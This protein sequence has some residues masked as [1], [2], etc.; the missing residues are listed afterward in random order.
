M[1]T[2][3]T[4]I[5]KTKYF[6]T[7]I[8]AIMF[9]L[10]ITVSN[11]IKAQTSLNF[12]GT[13]DYV[14]TNYSGILGDNDRTVE[15]WFKTS[16]AGPKGFIEWGTQANAQRFTIGVN[17]SKIRVE[18]FG[19]GI[20]STTNI[21]DDKWHHVAVVYNSSL[22]TNKLSIYIDGALDQS[23]N[24]HT[25]LNTTNTANVMIGQSNLFANRPI[26][27]EM[28]E[29]RIWDTAKSQEEIQDGMFHELDGSEANLTAYYS[30]ESTTTAANG[31]IDL[32][33]G[34]NGTMNNMDA[35]DI[36]SS[37]A[38]IRTT[39]NQ[40]NIRG[41]W[42]ST[43]MA[44]SL[45]SDGLWMNVNS[46]LTQT[47]YATFGHNNAGT[48][49]VTNDLPIGIEQR[50]EQ[51]WNVEET[52][53]VTS[54][55]TFDLSTIHGNPVVPGTPND[56]RLLYRPGTTGP[57]T[58]LGPA[59]LIANADQVTFS[60]VDLNNGYYTIGTVDAPF[61]PLPIE[62]LNFDAF[63]NQSE[64]QL[65]WQTASEINNDYF[66]IERSGEN[67][68]WEEINI[69]S[70]AGNSSTLLDYA[71]VDNQ[72]LKGTSYY[73]LKQT[74][75]DGSFSYSN[76]VS[77]KIA[78]ISAIE[79]IAYPNPTNQDITIIGSEY[80]LAEINIIDLLGQDVSTLTSTI[81]ISEEKLS[82]D[83]SQLNTG[84]YFI[85]TKNN[86]TTIHKQ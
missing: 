10:F 27:G 85:K 76:I 63:V 77:I 18:I 33:S 1:K 25:T 45:E 2:T 28:D 42:E 36:V 54:N 53:M 79:L 21:N 29:V 19:S 60:N 83:L 47:N 23:G 48:S 12:D 84:T 52:G 71:T 80:E 46:P 73:R 16:E 82:I 68:L 58:D 59:N 57:F 51:I 66:T 61:S 26:N 8:N 30:M 35:A 39:N 13:D 38:A 6:R 32:A 5:A 69:I 20:Q 22:P 15:F 14:S 67:F 49:T 11:S 9:I 40:N 41:I 81:A 4:Q 55:I 43:N 70:G 7:V 74:D 86:V 75:L 72:P 64:V 65:T 37:Y 17:S 62:L 3:N 78:D 50:Y 44:N 34:N 56:Y 31:V 24:F